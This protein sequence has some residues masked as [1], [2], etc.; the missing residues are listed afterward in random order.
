M[1]HCQTKE[2]FYNQLYTIETCIVRLHSQKSRKKN[3]KMINLYKKSLYPRTNLIQFHHTHNCQSSLYSATCNTGF[4]FISNPSMQFVYYAVGHNFSVSFRKMTLKNLQ[5]FNKVFTYNMLQNIHFAKISGFVF[6]AR[7][8]VFIL[9]IV[10]VFIQL[11][12]RDGGSVSIFYP[13]LKKISRWILDSTAS[14]RMSV[15]NH[16]SKTVSRR[17]LPIS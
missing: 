3:D 2:K 9:A 12:R 8:Q 5:H 1:I 17:C 6:L 11:K 16:A 4:S 15:R 14:V 13:P 7:V 10:V